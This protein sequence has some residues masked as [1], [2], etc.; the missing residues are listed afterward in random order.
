[1][2][3]V[4]LLREGVGELLECDVAG[5]GDDEVGEVLVEL[6]RVQA[7]LAAVVAKFTAVFDGRRAW[8]ADGAKSAGAWLARHCNTAKA[9]TG[10]QVRLARRL[11]TMPV[12]VAA[13]GAGEIDENH[14]GVLARAADSPR[15]VVAAA[16]PEAEADLVGFAKE[17]DF[18][19]FVRAV[20]HWEDTVD[21]DGAE[22]QAAADH[23]ARRL[24]VS[25]T[26][27]GN[28]R[29]DGQLDVLGGTEFATAL[30]RIDRELFLAD[31]EAAKQIHGA[32]TSVEHL[33]RT[34]AQR[35]ADALVEMA[36]RALAMPRH[37]RK[38]L[39][40][41]NVMVGYETFAGR[42]CELF[43]RLPVTPGQVASLLS[44]AEIERVVFD[45][46]NRII[47]LGVRKR[48]FTGGLRR[49]IEIR[50]RHCTAPGC[51]TPADECQA[52][53]IH[54]HAHGGRTEQGNGQNHC[55]HHN[56]RK[57]A[58]SGHARGP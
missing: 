7:Q 35:R 11:R 56:R 25:E 10:R 57:G 22:D 58:K 48:F 37:A 16:F 34:S 46:P 39:P 18:A 36:R 4:E 53:H 19:G 50:D 45:G 1:M 20:K 8:A 44:E 29:I 15:P 6:H 17:L 30:R 26:F 5:L 55:G 3:E 31:M 47:E 13:L 41:I 33:G 21:E 40:L 23:A 9:A 2:E 27:R 43:N 32:A 51:D 28:V 12:T 42:T 38:P 24:H 14:A 54:P 52:D 49:V